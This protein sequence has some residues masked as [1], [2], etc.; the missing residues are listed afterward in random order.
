MLCQR[1]EITLIIFCLMLESLIRKYLVQSVPCAYKD[2]PT[3][4]LV[5]H[6]VKQPL[7]GIKKDRVFL[8]YTMMMI[9]RQT[10]TP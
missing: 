7:F 1:T 4:H 10:N 6:L 2:N 8:R 9:Y 3:S 5:T